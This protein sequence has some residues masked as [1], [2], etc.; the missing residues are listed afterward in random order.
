MSQISSIFEEIVL[1]YPKRELS[2]NFVLQL[3]K[4]RGNLKAGNILASQQ[5]SAIEIIT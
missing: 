2:S 3:V 4:D 1:S 5:T